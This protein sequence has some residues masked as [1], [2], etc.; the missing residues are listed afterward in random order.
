MNELVRVQV[1]ENQEQVV[2]AREVHERLGIQKDFTDWFKN[3]ADKMGL[4]EGETF[5]PFRGNR[6]GTGIGKPQMDFLIPLYIAKNFCLMSRGKQAQAIRDYFI[7]VEKAWNTPEKIMAR[8]LQMANKELNTYHEQVVE[9]QSKVEADAPKVLFADAVSASETSILIGC[10][11]KLL[12]Q[13]GIDIGPYKLFEWL[14]THGYLIKRSGEDHNIPTQKA[15]NLRL[16]EIKE[17]VIRVHTGKRIIDK[18]VKVTGQGQLYFVKLFL[19]Q[20]STSATS[21]KVQQLEYTTH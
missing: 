5:T 13:N 18:I 4:M 17:T 7:T 3:Q 9:L 12:N 14:R 1:N 6:A 21:A 8:A 11:A 19:S 20:K 10:L 16:F 2:S 15:M